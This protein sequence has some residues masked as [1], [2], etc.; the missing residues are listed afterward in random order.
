MRYRNGLS[1]FPSMHLSRS[2]INHANG[3][4]IFIGDL[5]T[6]VLPYMAGKLLIEHDTKGPELPDFDIR[7]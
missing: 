5:L 1:S 2:V 6:V 7:K 3:G 4:L